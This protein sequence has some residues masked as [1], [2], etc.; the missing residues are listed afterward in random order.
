MKLKLKDCS[1]NGHS[2]NNIN[3][4]KTMRMNVTEKLMID[5]A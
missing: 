5:N 4:G 3:N 2:N 1:S